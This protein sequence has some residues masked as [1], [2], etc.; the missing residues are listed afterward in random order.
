[1]RVL[2]SAVQRGIIDCSWVPLN[3]FCKNQDMRL[4]VTACRVAL[5]LCC[6]G[7]IQEDNV[8]GM[9][10]RYGMIYI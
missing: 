8:R 9:F 1:M 10:D 2:A 4:V 7:G 5:Q 3:A 6:A